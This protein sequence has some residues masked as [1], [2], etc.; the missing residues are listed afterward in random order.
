MGDVELQADA[1]HEQ[2]DA[3]LA[4]QL[5]DVERRFWKEERE[6]GRPD[7]ADQRRSEHQSRGDLADDR[8]LSGERGKAAAHLRREHDDEQ[9]DDEERERPAQGLGGS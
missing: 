5:Q 9:L 2:D 4:Q 8:R 1:E 6:G 3:D 7:L